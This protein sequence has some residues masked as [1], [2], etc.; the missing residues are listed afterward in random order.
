[1]LSMESNTRGSENPSSKKLD[2]SRIN[3]NLGKVFAVTEDAV[4]LIRDHDFVECNEA[5]VRML[6]AKD[7]QQVLNTHP[8]ALSPK[9]QPCG[10]ASF[11]KANEMMAQAFE[12]GFHRF[13]WI[14]RRFFPPI[15]MVV[16]G[17]ITFL[18]QTEHEVKSDAYE[19]LYIRLE[20]G[21]SKGSPRAESKQ[22]RIR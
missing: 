13:E 22:S 14:H 4:L 12:K 8:S 20:N 9:F 10:K 16:F 19:I 3:Q 15:E 7:R 2:L 5:T 1:M 17:S 18:R 11:V 6:N 21:K